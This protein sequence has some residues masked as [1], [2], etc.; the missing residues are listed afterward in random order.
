MTSNTIVSRPFRTHRH[1]LSLYP[2]KKSLTRVSILLS[3]F[4]LC[5]AGL[6]GCGGA[7]CDRIETE[8]TA[9]LQRGPNTSDTHI[10]MTIPFVIAN[11]LVEPHIQKIK[12][13]D[14][15]LSNLGSL[16]SYFGKLS[17]APTRM[18]I[19]PA[20]QD[21]LGFRL[22]FEVRRNGNK[23]FGMYLESEVKPEIDLATGKVTI[24][25]TPDVL[26]K[27]TP[28]LAPDAKQN[29]GDLIYDQI[30]G[31]ARLLV[32]RSLV[33][34]V[35]GSTLERLID[36]FYNMAKQK[37][38][39]KL[40]QMSQ[41]EFNLPDVPLSNARITSSGDNGGRLQIGITTTLPVRKGIASPSAKEP[42]RHMISIRTSGSVAA[43]LVNWAMAKGTLPNRYNAE[44]KAKKD[45]EFWPGLDWISGEEAPMKIYLWDIEQPCMRLTMSATPSLAVRGGNIEVTAKA[46]KADDVEAT[47]V[48]KIGVWFKLLWKDAINMT[49]KKS[50]R[51][52]MKVA[53]KE[54][55]I[56]VEKA[57]IEGDEIVSEIYLTDDVQ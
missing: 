6:T 42:S 16:A 30:P 29:L 14:I 37:M 19:K 28:G 10:E 25:F 22:D 49:Q 55:M 5:S 39:P 3:L 1:Y 44:G 13:I 12:P 57:A 52:K 36:T 4:A 20:S 31:P 15:P 24:G 50:A 8:R 54:M 27:A 47:A 53:G 34:S 40:S 7:T 18:E 46:A 45:G 33:D 32:S 51:I 56:V 38:L 17:I 26:Q 2:T 41:L 43:E 48:T 23:A 21:H 35:V 11:R 9:F